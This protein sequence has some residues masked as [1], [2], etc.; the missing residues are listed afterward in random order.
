M[1]QPKKRKKFT[2]I[3]VRDDL[4]RWLKIEAAEQGV[5]MYELVEKLLAKGSKGRPWDQ[6]AS[7]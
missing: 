5:P 7:A 3:K 1:A 6:A 4:R 2:T